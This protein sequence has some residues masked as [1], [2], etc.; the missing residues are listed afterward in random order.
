MDY[1]GFWYGIVVL[2]GALPVL[3]G[4]GIATLW[5][6]RNGRRRYGLIA[7]AVLGGVL[8]GFCIFSAAI[9]FL[10]A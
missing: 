7:P 1:Y 4:A 5:A 3:V 10:R 9:L 6:W 2:F 8:S